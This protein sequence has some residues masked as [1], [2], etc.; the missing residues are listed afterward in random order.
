[1]GDKKLNETE[2]YVFLC[3]TYLSKVDDMITNGY[4]RYDFKVVKW[5]NNESN[6]LFL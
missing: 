2:S 3:K 6:A 4:E 1:M 5:I